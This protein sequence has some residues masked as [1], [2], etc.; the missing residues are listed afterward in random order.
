MPN[1]TSPVH[2][3]ELFPWYDTDFACIL[4]VFAMVVVALFSAV[5]LTVVWAEPAFAP[6]LWVPAVLLALSLLAA[7]SLS[8][9]LVRRQLRRGRAS[10]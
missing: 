4:L 5:G 7:G 8:F 9:R 2:R 1:P 10:S 6:H 3:R